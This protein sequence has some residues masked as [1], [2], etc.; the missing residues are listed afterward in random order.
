MKCFPG[1]YFKLPHSYVYIR[2]AD[3]GA[4]SPKT[5]K[6]QNCSFFGQFLIFLVDQT[7]Q[8]YHIEGYIQERMREYSDRI[9]RCLYY[10]TFISIYP[11]VVRVWL[12]QVS[13]FCQFSSRLVMCLHQMY[14][15]LLYSPHATCIGTAV[16]EKVREA[17]SG[18][19]R[20]KSICVFG[21]VSFAYLF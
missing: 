13:T 1:S 10:C 19:V 14:Y 18:C 20:R 17:N 2:D 9:F 4:P 11:C 12:T 7:P 5:L 3:G 15:K 6:M 21:F 16:K 8:Q